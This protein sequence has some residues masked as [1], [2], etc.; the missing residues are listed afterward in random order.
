M[1]KKIKDY[2]DMLNEKIAEVLSGYDTAIIDGAGRVHGGLYCMHY[3]AC[4]YA[5]ADINGNM[6]CYEE[7][8]H[9]C[10]FDFNISMNEDGTINLPFDKEALN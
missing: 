9:E 6:A 2:N 4:P 7:D 3:K 10:N 5:T 1:K 8:Y